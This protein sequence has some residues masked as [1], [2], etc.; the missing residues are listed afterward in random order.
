M[1]YPPSRVKKQYKI[2]QSLSAHLPGVTASAECSTN[3]LA[4]VGRL[5]R[6]QGRCTFGRSI[7][8]DGRRNVGELF[9][10]ARQAVA[11]LAPRY[12]GGIGG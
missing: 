10:H 8:R 2:D 11:I 5:V 3:T 9:H 12:Q 1:A 7:L 6:T 4:P